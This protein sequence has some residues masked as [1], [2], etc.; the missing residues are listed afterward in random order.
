[1]KLKY[2]DENYN[3]KYLDMNATI[4]DAIIKGYKPLLQINGEYYEIEL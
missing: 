1:M 2:V 4:T 3:I